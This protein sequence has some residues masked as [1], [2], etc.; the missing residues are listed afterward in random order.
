MPEKF[1]SG[2]APVYK[3]GTMLELRRGTKRGG[4]SL[5]LLARAAR[6]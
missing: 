1:L 2:M 5:Y 3:G 4:D 6:L